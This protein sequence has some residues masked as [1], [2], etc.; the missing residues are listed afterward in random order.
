M[1]KEESLAKIKR[2]K[3]SIATVNDM[4]ESSL[5]S[6][7]LDTSAIRF[8]DGAFEQLSKLQEILNLTVD[9]ADY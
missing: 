3:S 7:A 6:L 5:S 1:T 2:N 4:M 8:K 9:D